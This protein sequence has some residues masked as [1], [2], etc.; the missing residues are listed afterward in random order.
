M[1]NRLSLHCSDNRKR[2]GKSFSEK[3]LRRVMQLASIFSDVK[4]GYI[5][6]QFYY[7]DTK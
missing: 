7:I 2:I 3:S 5:K 4:R 1:A 6:S